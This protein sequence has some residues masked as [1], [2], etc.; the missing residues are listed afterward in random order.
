MCLTG[1]LRRAERVPFVVRAATKLAVVVLFRQCQ[2]KCLSAIEIFTSL[3]W[4]IGMSATEKV[5]MFPPSLICFHSSVIFRSPLKFRWW[6]IYREGSALIQMDL[7]VLFLAL[8]VLSARAL[9]FKTNSVLLTGF[10]AFTINK[11][12]IQESN[13]Q[14][15]VQ[16]SFH[17]R[18]NYLLQTSSPL[19][20]WCL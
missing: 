1:F 20:L 7:P 10:D 3:K 18:L 6:K 11:T 4:N 8:E 16:V 15:F 2:R 13:C 19:F 12:L 5:H 17:S 14:V 9:F